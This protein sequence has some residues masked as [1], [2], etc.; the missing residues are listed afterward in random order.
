MATMRT[1]GVN[2]AITGGTVQL[3]TTDAGKNWTCTTG[4]LGGG[5]SMKYLPGAC[6]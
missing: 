3:Q 4:A 6:R 2:A 1:Q 5:L